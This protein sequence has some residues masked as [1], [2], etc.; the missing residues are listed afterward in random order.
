[1]L[2]PTGGRINTD[3]IDNSAGAETSDHEVNIKRSLALPS[4]EGKLE[5]T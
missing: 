5:R 4:A 3:A 1:M 2:R